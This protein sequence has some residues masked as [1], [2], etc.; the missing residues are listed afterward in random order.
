M[1]WE[2]GQQVLWVCKTCGG[3]RLAWCNI[4]KVGR[5]YVYLAGYYGA[6]GR[7]NLKGEGIESY[8]TEFIFA[9]AAAWA[10]AVCR[11]ARE[12]AVRRRSGA[13]AHVLKLVSDQTLR[14]LM[15]DLGIDDPEPPELPDLPAIDAH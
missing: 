6:C 9:D 1:T 15:Q 3:Y 4:K 10:V 5:K 13:Y 12:D 11:Q 2:A 8:G 7:F 14:L